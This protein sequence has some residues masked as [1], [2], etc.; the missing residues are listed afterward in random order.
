MFRT[1]GGLRNGVSSLRGAISSRR[2]YVYGLA[3]V[4]SHLHGR[5]HVLGGHL[6]GCRSPSGS[7]G[8]DDIPPDGRHVDS[9]IGEHAGALEGPANEG[10]KKRFKRSKGALLGSRSPSDVV[11][12][13]TGCYARYKRSLRSYRHVLSCMAR[14]VALPRLGPIVGRVE[15]CGAVYGGYKTAMRS[16]GPQGHKNG[17][18]VCS[19]DMGSLT[20]CLSIIRFLPCKQVRGVFRRV[21]NVRLARNSLM[22]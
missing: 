18:I 1:L 11:S 6:T 10:P 17:T 14:I 7:D 8:G 4:G 5:G 16:R 21:F 9:R 3:H 2:R 15:R 20:I 12:V 22:G 13:D 19:T